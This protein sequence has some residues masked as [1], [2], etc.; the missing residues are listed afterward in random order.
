MSRV[1]ILSFAGKTPKIAPSAFLADGVRLA[2]DIEI[3]DDVSLWFNVSIR[4]DV[5]SIRIGAGSN[6]QDNSVVHVTGSNAPTIIGNN[7]TVGHSAIIHSCSIA[8]LC[9]IG[10]GAIVLDNAQIPKH[11]LIGAGS[12]VPPGKTYPEAHLILGSPAK[13]V[14]PLT[15]EEI[16]YFI[17]SA[18]IYKDLARQYKICI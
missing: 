10:M 9:I 1:S 16:A 6:I 11:S 3:A 17:K 8:D 7:V 15:E 12:V 14:R 2:G 13:A 5:N 18:Q 4:G